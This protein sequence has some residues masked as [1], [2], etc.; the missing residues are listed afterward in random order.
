MV[1]SERL[2]TQISDGPEPQ[3]VIDAAEVQVFAGPDKGHKFVLGCDSLIVGSAADCEVVLHDRTVSGRHAEIQSTSSGYYIRDLGSTNGVCIG[4][5]PIDRAPLCDGT[6]LSLG[7]SGLLVRALGEKCAIPLARAG[8]VA[9]MVARSVKM[10]AFVAALEQAAQTEATVLLEGETGSGKEVAAQALHEL[11][12]RRLGPFVTFDCGAVPAGLIAAE[13]FGSEKGAFTG[14]AAARAGL[15]ESAEGGT[16]FLDEIGELP[17]DLQPLLL[18]AV[19]RKRSRRIGAQSEIEHDVRIIAATNRN[20]VEE[21]RSGR[22]REDLFFRIA[23]ARLRLPPLRE[24]HE[25]IL[26][27]ADL[28][29]KEA[30]IELSAESI[31]VLTSYDWPGNVRELKHTM[32]RM[33]AQSQDARDAIVDLTKQRASKLLDEE[34]RPR[35]WLEARRLAS[36]ATEREYAQLLLLQTEGNLTRAAELAG[37]TRQAFTKLAE[38]HGL[39]RHPRR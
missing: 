2:T 20:L 8:E 39:H 27:L 11:S 22:F 1:K 3:L 30:G 9:G 32:T 29:A 24:R 38:K 35:P 7:Q 18:G 21:V 23:V 34:G 4:S 16:L 10:R 26:F 36:L 6:R 5:Q 13:L 17:L 37:V 25:D 15:L 12:S 19:E 28:F 14:A 31:A 33:V